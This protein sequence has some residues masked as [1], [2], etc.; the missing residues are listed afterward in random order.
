LLYWPALTSGKRYWR[1]A[2]DA[3]AVS[4]RHLHNGMGDAL[5]PTCGRVQAALSEQAVE[6]VQ[7]WRVHVAPP[8]QHLIGC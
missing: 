2:H 6:R 3:L 5:R 4:G 1:S 8:Q 7:M